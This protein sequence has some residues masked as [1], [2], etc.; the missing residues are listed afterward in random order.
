MFYWRILCLPLLFPYNVLT[1]WFCFSLLNHL[2][3]RLH[4][5]VEHILGRR[6][7]DLDFS[8]FACTQEL[9]FS[10]AV[11]SQVTFC[12]FILDW[13]TQQHSLINLEKDKREQHNAVVQYEQGPAGRQWMVISPEY[14]S[15]LLEL[16]LSVPC[17]AKIW[18]CPDTVYQLIAESDLSVSGIIQHYDRWRVRS[19]WERLNR[20]SLTLV[21]KW[22][23]PFCKPEDCGCSITMSE[24][25]CSVV[26]PLVS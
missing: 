16:N 11:S 3:A 7:L 18:G 22:W 23:W 15:K 4:S 13:L 24:P 6:C 1:Q 9:V 17:I 20:G 19:V 21:I 25:P 5:W 12:P 14:L 10:N 8:E 26:T 2:L